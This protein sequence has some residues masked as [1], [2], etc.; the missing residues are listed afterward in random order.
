MAV[1]RRT[2]LGLACSSRNIELVIAFMNAGARD[3]GGYIDGLHRT[4]I[5]CGDHTSRRLLNACPYT[6]AFRRKT[7]NG[8]QNP[9]NKPQ[10]GDS[11]QRSSQA[12]RRG[13]E[14]ENEGSPSASMSADDSC[15]GQTDAPKEVSR[16]RLAATG[17]NSLRALLKQNAVA[18]ATPSPLGK[19]AEE[20]PAKQLEQPARVR[21]G[22]GR[23]QGSEQ[24]AAGDAS[25]PSMRRGAKPSKVWSPQLSAEIVVILVV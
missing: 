25:E 4:L 11:P 17:V 13:K 20:Q 18:L 22:R 2:A 24:A 1:C 12:R 14:Q 5:R 3:A 10:Q 21:R 15:G 8:G 19:M 16:R 23:F 6:T 9:L 7:L